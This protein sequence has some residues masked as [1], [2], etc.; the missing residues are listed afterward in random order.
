MSTGIHTDTEDG[1]HRERERSRPE[2]EKT[3]DEEKK[4]EKEK[5]EDGKKK[6]DG[7]NKNLQFPYKKL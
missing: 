7:E 6:E 5:K 4:E 1:M 2:V 3:E